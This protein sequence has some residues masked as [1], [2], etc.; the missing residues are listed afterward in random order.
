VV[1]SL[2]QVESIGITHF[3]SLSFHFK[4][5]LHFFDFDFPFLHFQYLEQS[6]ASEYKQGPGQ[7]SFGHSNGEFGGFVVGVVIGLLQVEDL[8]ITHCFSLSFHS[9]PFLQFFNVD[10]PFLHFQYLEQSFTFVYKQGPGQQSFGHSKVDCNRSLVI[11][12]I[13]FVGLL[14]VDL[15]G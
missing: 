14:Q 8:G 4:P 6:S 2:L 3:F 10:S 12:N 5:F 7:Q 1:I 11:I 15:E 9:K 13:V